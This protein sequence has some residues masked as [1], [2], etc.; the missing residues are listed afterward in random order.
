MGNSCSL[1]PR[2]HTSFH[3]LHHHHH[4]SC[5]FIVVFFFFGIRNHYGDSTINGD[6]WWFNH[7]IVHPKWWFNYSTIVPISTTVCRDFWVMCHWQFGFKGCLGHSFP[8]PVL[9]L[10]VCVCSSTCGKINLT[11]EDV[12][13]KVV[14]WL[15]GR[16]GLFSFHA[17]FYQG[18]HMR[19]WAFLANMN[20]LSW[21]LI[22]C[23]LVQVV[24]KTN[25]SMFLYFFLWR[26]LRQSSNDDGEY[27]SHEMIIISL[28]SVVIESNND[29]KPYLAPYLFL[30]G[31]AV[32]APSV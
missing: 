19:S 2:F 22:R 1:L 9:C 31:H 29:G 6:S 26:G 27:E 20:L 5:P 30:C 25:A 16:F 14:W 15:V 28:Y 10:C 13:R 23:T 24:R 7:S 21:Q 4:S 17:I 8:S 3:Q 18:G 32:G 11:L 12:A